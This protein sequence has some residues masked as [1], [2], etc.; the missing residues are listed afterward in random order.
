VAYL[1]IIF[2]RKNDVLNKGWRIADL[3]KE[4]VRFRG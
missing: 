2:E 3:G 4:E 1:L